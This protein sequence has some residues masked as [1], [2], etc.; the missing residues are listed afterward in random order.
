LG[1]LFFLLT[2]GG[3]S[4][5][6][7]AAPPA[8][9]PHPVRQLQQ[10]MTPC[11]QCCSPSG[12]CSLAY[13]QSA[14]FCCGTQG[15]VSYCC[16]GPMHQI[17]CVKCNIGYQCARSGSAHT[18]HDLNRIC[19]GHGGAPGGSSSGSGFRPRGPGS[20]QTNDVVGSLIGEPCSRD[21]AIRRAR[22]Q[23]SLAPSVSP[24]DPPPPAML[25]LG[26]PSLAPP[27]LQRSCSW[28]SSR[29]PSTAAA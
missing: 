7:A 10:T 26:P 27:R 6:S 15:S 29:S 16:P 9:P 2:L 20:S 1:R 25:A 4:A 28:G 23:R 11:Q 8:P 21:R 3:A 12:D 5:A 17:M 19:D 14:G 22:A 18:Q 24:R 13:H